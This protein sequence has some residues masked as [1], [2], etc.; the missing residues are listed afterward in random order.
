MGK[1]LYR[2]Y[3]TYI[4]VILKMRFRSRRRSI[5]VFD[6]D[7]TLY[8]T[9][10]YINTY[11]KKQELYAKIPV[12]EHMRSN[13]FEAEKKATI[14]FLTTR[15]I[16]TLQSTRKRLEKD[17]KGMKYSLVMVDRSIEK[18]TFLKFFLKG[19]DKVTYF[20]DLSFYQENGQEKFYDDVINKVKELPLTYYG[21]EHIKKINKL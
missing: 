4:R 2:I 19:A 16:K 12:F 14:V 7:N 11:H 15:K 20:D 10:P 8:N 5:V 9:W 13:V 18:L 17:F 3:K 21:A 1:L 6:L